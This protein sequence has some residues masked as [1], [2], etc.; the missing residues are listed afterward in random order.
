MLRGQHKSD[1]DGGVISGKLPQRQDK[2]NRRMSE[3]AK[4]VWE[5]AACMAVA[6]TLALAFGRLPSGGYW[7]KR[8]EQPAIYWT[9]MVIFAVS[10]LVVAYLGL[11]V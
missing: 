5:I 3:D 6:W 8:N 11:R 4:Q 10:C 7:I 9:L 1:I 2:R